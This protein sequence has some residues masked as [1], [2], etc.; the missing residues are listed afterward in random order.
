MSN[1]FG[2]FV[3]TFKGIGFG[4][5]FGV[6]SGYL[7]GMGTFLCFNFYMEIKLRK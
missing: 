6:Y 3:D 4:L 7:I 2:F 1:R 5:T